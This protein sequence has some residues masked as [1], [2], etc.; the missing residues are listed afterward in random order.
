ML[1]AELIALAPMGGYNL[2]GSLLPKYRGRAPV[3][4]ML[5]NGERE[6]G[7]TLHHM[8]ARADAGDIVAQ[9]E[10]EI[11]DDDTALTLYRKIAPLG[12]AL[13]GDYHPLIVSGMAPRRAQDL[14]Q[15]IRHALAP[16]DPAERPAAERVTSGV[17][18]R[19]TG[20]SIGI[21]PRGGSSTW[22]AP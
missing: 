6:A 13:I 19:R 21:G 9:R 20:A 4:W 2:H 16:L 1:P 18:R 17:A 3:N 10:V 12:A 5:A 11:T 7:V 14:A 15:G 22:S 8:V